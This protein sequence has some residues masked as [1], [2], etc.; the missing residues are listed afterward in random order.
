LLL[1]CVEN[2]KSKKFEMIRID[3][4]EEEFKKRGGGVVVARLFEEELNPP[5]FTTLCSLSFF[6]SPLLVN[7]NNL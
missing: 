2:L 4:K 5:R 6:S 7:L 1:S 3:S